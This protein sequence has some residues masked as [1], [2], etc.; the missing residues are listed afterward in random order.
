MSDH[1]FYHAERLT[2][3][4]VGQ[5]NLEVSSEEIKSN[6][7]SIATNLENHENEEAEV[8]RKTH[9]HLSANTTSLA[10]LKAWLIGIGVG[11]SVIFTILN[12]IQL[13]KI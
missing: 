11:V 3:L 9:E 4:E 1:N 5:K 7:A 8:W 6:I 13:Y 10:A 2:R 12:I